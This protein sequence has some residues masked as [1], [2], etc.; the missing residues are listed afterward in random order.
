MPNV[1]LNGNRILVLGDTISYEQV[2]GLL[3]HHVAG[4][5]YT[6]V[7]RGTILKGQLKPGDSIGLEEEMAFNATPDDELR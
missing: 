6:I 4:T 1:F 3:H 2:V 7:Y 5:S